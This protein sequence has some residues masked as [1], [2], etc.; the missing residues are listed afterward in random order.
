[1]YNKVQLVHSDISEFNVLIHKDKPYLIDLGQ[2]VLLDHYNAHKFL[3][4][5]IHNIVKYFK[6]YNI[7]S[8]EEKI[9]N[10]ITKNKK[11]K[12]KWNT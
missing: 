4:R 12:K 10:E 11:W 1:M 3:K 7:E 6:K 2:G 5:D 8:D 9:F